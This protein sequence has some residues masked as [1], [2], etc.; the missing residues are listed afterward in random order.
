MMSRRPLMR[1]A[2]ELLVIILGVLIA[3]FAENRWQQYKD[4]VEGHEYLLR[5]AVELETNRESLGVERDWS[6]QGCTSAELVLR[7]LRQPANEDDAA[8]ILR[9]AASAAMHVS[10][11]YESVTYDDLVATGRLSLIE[12]ANL[13]ELLVDAY[14]SLESE[15]VWRPSVE[16]EFRW[17]VLRTLPLEYIQRVIEECVREEGGSMISPTLRPCSVV[18]AEGTPEG[19]LS[20]LR[21]VPDLE[22]DAAQRVYVMCRLDDHLDLVRTSLDSLASVLQPAIQ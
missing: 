15:Q 6:S 5:L 16:D 8:S 22:G 3:L 20:R 21:T 11:G 17:A 10:R 9:S 13:R 19:W 4:E 14:S 18:P 7:Y 12:D 2:T 1:S